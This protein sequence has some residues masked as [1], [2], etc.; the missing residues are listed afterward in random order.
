MQ[1]ALLQMPIGADQNMRTAADAVRRAAVQGAQV[2]VLPEMFCCLSQTTDFSQCA[3]PDGGARW[4]LLRQIAREGIWLPCPQ[5][6]YPR[7]FAKELGIL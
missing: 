7:L 3:E 6:P 4:Q 2:A 5:Q 1:V